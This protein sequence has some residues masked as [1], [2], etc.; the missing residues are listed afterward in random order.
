L[1]AVV[2]R[3]IGALALA[4]LALEM[5]ELLGSEWVA[6]GID[7][8]VAALGLSPSSPRSNLAIGNSSTSFSGSSDVLFAV[9]FV[10]V[11]AMELVVA[12][13]V[14]FAVVF[15]ATLT[16]FAAAFA[17]YVPFGM[18][19]TALPAAAA[20]AGAACCAAAFAGEPETLVAATA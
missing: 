19:S 7:V 13:M 3:M 2:F 17:T 9:A 16:A 1:A 18:A 10:V 14:T 12:F 8:V 6:L 20:A 4:A 5:T 15:E 11:F